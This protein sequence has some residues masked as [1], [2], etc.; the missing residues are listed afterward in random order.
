MPTR[1]EIEV[2]PAK[3]HAKLKQLRSKQD[4]LLNDSN[5]LDCL[6]I[7]SYEDAISS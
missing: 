3:P 2:A 5:N 7:F 1:L 6:T 4:G